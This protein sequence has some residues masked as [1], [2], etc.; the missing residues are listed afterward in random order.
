MDRG[1]LKIWRKLLDNPIWTEKR[2]F[3]RFECWFDI[4]MEAR[5][6][7]EPAQKLIKGRLITCN[8]GQIIYSLDT[9][10]RRWHMSKTQAKRILDLFTR[11]SMIVYENET[12]T[13]RITVCNYE[14]YNKL[15]NENETITE[16]TRN[17]HGT[18]TE[19]T[20][21]RN[22]VRKKREVPNG[23]LS[24]NGEKPACP[25]PPEAIPYIAIIQ[26][27]NQVCG[28]RYLASTQSY[29][30]HIKARWNDGFRYQDF[31]SVID[32]KF[33]EW[34]TDEKMVKF[35]RPE[36]LFGTKMP[37]YLGCTREAKGS[38]WSGNDTGRF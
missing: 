21:E 17:E 3:S 1:H 10:A 15:R 20:E 2:H 16:R 24:G 38:R 8:Y 12:V 9:W 32:L 11:T 28:S 34:G 5:F 4:L 33:K 26:H 35:L 18:N 6:S 7:H 36:T 25:T 37:T 19:P 13:V 22:K 31:V 29:R 27:L 30:R 23:T 14:K